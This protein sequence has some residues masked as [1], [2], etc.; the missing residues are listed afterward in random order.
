MSASLPDDRRS[1]LL[2][3]SLLLLILLYRIGVLLSGSINLGFDEAYY[4]YWSQF[5]AL[6]YYSKPPFM[7]WLVALSTS[8]FGN[9]EMA[10]RLTSLISYPVVAWLLFRMGRR[11]FD[12]RTGLVAALLFFTMPAVALGNILITTDAVLLLCW[13]ASLSVLFEALQHNRYRDWL[14]LGICSG[15]GLLSK[16]TMVLLAPSLLLVLL[17]VPVWRWHLINPRLY[18]SAALALLIFLP[19]IIWNIQHDFPTLQHTVEIS[20]LQ[21]A[22]VKFSQLSGFV[23]SQFAVFGLSFALFV[24]QA[25]VLIKHWQNDRLHALLPLSLVFLLV[26]MGQALF[27]GANANWAAPAYVAASLIVAVYLVQNHRWIVLLVLLT[28]NLLLGSAVYH[29]DRV[30]QVLDIP[31]AQSNDSH[32]ALRGWQQLAARVQPFM[33]AHPHAI[34]LGDSRHDLAELIYYLRPHPLDA[35]KWNPHR[36]VKD[37]FDLVTQMKDKTGRNF[38]YVTQGNG[39]LNEMTAAFAATEKLADITLSFGPDYRKNYSVFLLQ[40]FKGYP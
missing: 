23:L 21:Q 39:L 38:I 1:R 13:T 28:T 10:V 11:W 37:Q 36:R 22:G 18:L 5:P 29:Y 24:W 7:A 6:G 33:N 25:G 20:H 8:M 17:L 40:D 14:L 34:L 27:G 19:N 30:L 12:A 2:F 32:K 15:L 26:I 9:S 31:L 16:Y 3:W 4:W 35:V